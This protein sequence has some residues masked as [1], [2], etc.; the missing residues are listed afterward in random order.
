MFQLDMKFLA[1]SIIRPKSAS[2]CGSLLD[3]GNKPFYGA[4]DRTQKEETGNPEENKGTR[5]TRR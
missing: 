1:V 2:Y 3:V 5:V 4:I